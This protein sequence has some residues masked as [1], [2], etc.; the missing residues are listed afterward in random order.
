[1]EKRI[2]P[3][4]RRRSY[5]I[6]ELRCGEIAVMRGFALSSTELDPVREEEFSWE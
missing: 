5:R 2:D 1:M 3:R 6:P 4:S